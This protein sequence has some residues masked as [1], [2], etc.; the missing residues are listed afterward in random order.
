MRGKILGSP[1][2]TA[3]A[4]PSSRRLSPVASSRVLGHLKIFGSE[5][6][7]YSAKECFDCGI[8]HIP[9]DRNR[10]GLVGEMDIGENLVLKNL[11]APSYSS[12]HGWHIDKKSHSQTRRRDD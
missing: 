7:Q 5:K 10:M 6:N 8:A 12:L 4:S 11:H 2:L 1:A 9:E 3:T